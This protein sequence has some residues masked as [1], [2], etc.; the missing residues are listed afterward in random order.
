MEEQTQMRLDDGSRV[1]A[2]SGGPAGSFFSYFLLDTAE[3]AGAD[4][5]ADVYEPKDFT[6]T[7]PPACTSCGGVVHES[8]VQTLAADGG[9]ARHRPTRSAPGRGQ[10]R[11]PDARL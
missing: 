5:R 4:L 6:R 8:L 11:H 9:A 3:R 1:A 2:T 7:G 10:R